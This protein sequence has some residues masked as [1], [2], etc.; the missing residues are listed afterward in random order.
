ML[1]GLQVHYGLRGM[2]RGVSNRF[3]TFGP[4]IPVVPVGHFV[5]IGL[6]A[7]IYDYAWHLVGPTIDRNI[8]RMNS[9]QLICIA[10][11]EGMRMA[12]ATINGAK[13]ES[14]KRSTPRQQAGGLQEL[15]SATRVEYLGYPSNESLRSSKTTQR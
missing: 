4:P 2:R 6:E 10:F 14:S 1:L 7:E 8:E 13:D 11:I 5:E 9:H 12:V 3:V 15:G